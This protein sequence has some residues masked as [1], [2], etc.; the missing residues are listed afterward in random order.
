MKFKLLEDYRSDELNKNEISVR[1]ADKF[2]ELGFDEVDE[3]NGISFSKTI[4]NDTATT[5]CQF[6]LDKEAEKYSSYV[7]KDEDGDK[8]TTF[9]QSGTIFEADTAAD[10]FIEY[11]STIEQ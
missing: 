6:Y 10:E 5:Y 8:S 3:M 9:Q 7:T 4:E 1:V 2:T 11:L